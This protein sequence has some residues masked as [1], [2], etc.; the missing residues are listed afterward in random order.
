MI[1]DIIRKLAS[2]RR[3]SCS[4][5]VKRVLEVMKELFCGLFHVTLLYMLILCRIV[6]RKLEHI[7]NWRHWWS[8]RLCEKINML[9]EKSPT[10]EGNS[11][12]GS[13]RFN[14]DS[15]LLISV[16]KLDYQ[17]RVTMLHERLGGSQQNWIWRR[18]LRYQI[19]LQGTTGKEWSAKI[20]TTEGSDGLNQGIFTKL[21]K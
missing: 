19:L 5:L 12:K 21:L 10:C 14:H 2:K 1:D 17:N 15:T 7:L 20:I 16:D 8:H 18:S 6:L 11:C 4:S 9:Y 3:I 13:C